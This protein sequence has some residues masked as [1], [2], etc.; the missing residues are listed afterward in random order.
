M[1]GRWPLAVAILLVLL[2]AAYFLD[3]TC[4]PAGLVRGEHFF[5][6][7]PTTYWIRALASSDP[8]TQSGAVERLR[9]KPDAVPV[10]VEVLNAGRAAPEVRCEAAHLLRTADASAAAPPLIAAL[11]DPDRHVRAVAA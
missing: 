5:E 2:G 7:R 1:K 3:P 6:G 8:V 9:D 10:L 4:V 11:H